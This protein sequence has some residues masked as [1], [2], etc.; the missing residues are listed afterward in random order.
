MAEWIIAGEP[1]MELNEADIRRFS[2]E[3][4]VLGALEARIPEVLGRHYDNPFPGRSMDTARGQRR[5]PIH[6]GLV[7]L[8]VPGSKV[9]W[10]LGARGAFRRR[11]GAFAAELWRASLARSCGTGRGRS[12]PH[13]RCDPGSKRLWQDHG[14]GAGCLTAFLNHLCAAQMDIADPG[15]IAY[16][17]ILNARGGDRKRPDTVQR[18]GPDDLSAHLLARARLCAT[19]NACAKHAGRFPG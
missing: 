2:P 10:R 14:S 9:A 4:N 13:R 15:R 12:L 3:M 18:H 11:G 7:K 8:Q 6:A 19:S 16:T 5:S 17:Q 1:T